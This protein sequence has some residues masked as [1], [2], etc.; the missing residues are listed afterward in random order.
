MTRIRTSRCGVIDTCGTGGEG[1]Q[2]FNVS[3]AAAFVVAG[4]GV[5]VAKH[6]NRAASSRAGSFDLLEALG[7][8][9]D[10]VQRG[11]HHQPYGD[12]HR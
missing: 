7:V 2:T 1:A 9:A 3:T 11:H 5:P 6:G 10:R 12:D 4:A 8:H